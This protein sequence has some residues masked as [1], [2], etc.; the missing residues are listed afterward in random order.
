MEKMFGE[1]REASKLEKLLTQVK[2]L[3][4]RTKKMPAE[5]PLPVGGLAEAKAAQ[6]TITDDSKIADQLRAQVL[7]DESVVRAALQVVG[8][9]YDSLIATEGD[10]PYAQAVKARPEVAAEVLK[11]EMPVVAALKV[12]VGFKPYAEFTAKYGSEPEGIK[13]KIRQEA[14]NE[15]KREPAIKQP[16]APLFASRGGGRVPQASSASK[17]GLKDVFGR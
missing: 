9:D 5:K 4:E 17:H 8:V 16:V 1:V 15:E 11:A 2:M 3:A 13:E 14:L 12:A 7:R 10:T 6:E